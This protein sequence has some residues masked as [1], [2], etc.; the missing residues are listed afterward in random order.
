[1]ILTLRRQHFSV[2]LFALFITAFSA[3]DKLRRADTPGNAIARA[4][5]QYLYDTDIIGIVPAGVSSEDSAQIV[6]DYIDN[7]VRKM[8]VLNKAEKNLPDA[9]KN[10]E[11]QLLDYRN[12]LVTYA[13]EQELIK[14]RLDTSI[15]DQEIEEFYT[16]NQN[17]FELKDNIIKVLYLKLDS[18][19]PKLDKVKLWYRSSAAKDRKLLEDYA[20]Q[21]A[22]NYYFDDENWLFFDDLLKEV[23]LTLYDKEQFLKNNRFLELK[24]STFTYLINIKGFKVKSS[25]SP[26][27]FERDN[28]RNMILNQRKL[29]LIANM[30][31]KAYE[32]AVKNEDFEILIDKK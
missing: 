20:Y 10:V 24:D 22:I 32:D 2:L 17:S 16:A 3:C 30:E 31:K 23:P 29:K 11:K 28:I 14:Q 21:Y 13:Y 4:F 1:M 6:S 19:S 26:L 12:S 7:W 5:D 15:T 18:N 27:S 25:I 8:V 9:N